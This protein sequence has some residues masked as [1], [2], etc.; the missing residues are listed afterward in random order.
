M[1]A[2]YIGETSGEKEAV[3]RGL[4]AGKI[5]IHTLTSGVKIISQYIRHNIS[6]GNAFKILIG[7][8]IG[9]IP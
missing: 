9:K 2:K 8:P 7:T 1:R 4:S 6:S 5:I 3:D